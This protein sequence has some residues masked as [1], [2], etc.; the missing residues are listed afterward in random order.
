MP[1]DASIPLQV[2]SPNLGNELARGIQMGGRLQELAALRDQRQRGT[3]SRNALASLLTGQGGQEQQ[4]ALAQADPAL[5]MQYQKFQS[6]QSQTQ[7]EQATNRTAERAVRFTALGKRN[8]QLAVSFLQSELQREDL[9]DPERRSVAQNLQ[10][11]QQEGFEPVLQETQAE[12]EAFER[13]GTLESGPGP[14]KLG[15]GS[16]LVDPST[17]EEI[18]R[19]DERR[20]PTGRYRSEVDQFGNV[21]I[22]DSTTGEIVRREGRPGSQ[23]PRA[24]GGPKRR[25][26][27]QGDVFGA[28]EEGMGPFANMRAGINNVIGPFMSGIPFEGTNRSR[29]AIRNFN[30]EAKTALVNN[31]RFPVAEQE[32]VQR[33]LPDPGKFFQDPDAARQDLMELRSFLTNKRQQIQQSMQSGRVTQDEVG[34]LANQMEAINRVLGLMGDPDAPGEEGGG[35][36]SEVPQ[37]SERIGTYQGKPAYRTPD[38]RTVVVE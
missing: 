22:I 26:D 37:G 33:I 3:Q 14:V 21:T 8:P 17:G 12:L 30:Q 10:R 24:G 36:P 9:T 2:R 7:K 4:N 35:L 32:V 19:G 18:A 28:V 38:G 15:E 13:M 34:K 23:A 20:P 5:A 1:I 25:A 31:P 6:E 11:I 16:R 29:A 27:G